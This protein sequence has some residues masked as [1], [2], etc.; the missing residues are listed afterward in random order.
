MKLRIKGNSI[1]LR[2]TQSEV[3]SIAK[4]GRLESRTDF[5]SQVFHFALVAQETV[6][7]LSASFTQNT[8]L[9]TAS[10]VALSNWAAGEEVGLYGEQATSTEELLFIAVEKD[11]RC[12]DRSRAEADEADAYPHPLIKSKSKQS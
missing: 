5:I 4:E 8:L 6:P 7:S 11:F 1:R 2:L 3:A 10:C 9:V 12:L